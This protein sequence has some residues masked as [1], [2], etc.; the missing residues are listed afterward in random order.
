MKEIKIDK[1][2]IIYL[3]DLME[4]ENCEISRKILKKLE[5]AEKRIT[6]SSAKAKGRNLQYWVCE[7]L[8]KLF[9]VEY[10]QS[11]DNSLIQSRPMGQHGTDIIIRGELEKKFP[12]DIECKAQESLSIPN[13]VNQ[14]KTNCK[15][16]HKWLLVFK[17]K[18]ISVEP[19]VIMDWYTFENLL[20]GKYAI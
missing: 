14:A 5:R 17:K 12:F 9:N 11:D 3:K 4:L 18:S 20:S 6:T 7:R 19:M 10:N 16:N 1:N 15:N 8:S 2:E 13:W